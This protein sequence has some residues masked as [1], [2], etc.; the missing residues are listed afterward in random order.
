MIQ[1]I[2]RYPTRQQV[3]LL[4]QPK[5]ILVGTSD[6][7]FSDLYGDTFN[8]TVRTYP[9]SVS[10]PSTLNLQRSYWAL[11][12]GQQTY[13]TFSS[14]IYLVHSSLLTPN[15]FGLLYTGFLSSTYS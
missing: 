4:I 10:S 5:A 11:L 15:S 8:I 14:D 9:P 13:L 7:D 1:P 6:R 12:I 3:L 2:D